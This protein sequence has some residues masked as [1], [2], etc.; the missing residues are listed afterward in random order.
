MPDWIIKKTLRILKSKKINKKLKILIL[1]IAYKKNINDCRESPA[2]EVIKK[3][4]DKNFKVMYNDPYIN[5]IPKL[6][7]YN[8]NM[9]SIK[10][11]K[12]ILKTFDATI[13][14]TNH[15]NYDYE[16]I[17]KNS[18]LVIDTRNS[19]GKNFKN[20]YLA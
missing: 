1:G 20:I 18:S 6:R 15:D 4:K 8:F 19:Y 13:I 3:L 12:K 9:K 2:F 16:M 17:R 10:L 7:N 11:N 5:K 14:I